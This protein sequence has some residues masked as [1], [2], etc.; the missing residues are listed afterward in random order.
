MRGPSLPQSGTPRP[1]RRVARPADR[2]M[3]GCGGAVGGAWDT[4]PRRGRGDAEHEHGARSPLGDALGRSGRPRRDPLAPLHWP[5]VWSGST[6]DRS[7]TSSRARPPR[8][9]W[10]EGQGWASPSSSSPPAPRGKRMLSPFFFRSA[11]GPRPPP[12]S[13]SLSHHYPTH[14]IAFNGFIVGR[15]GG[16]GVQGCEFCFF[17]CARGE[18][19][20]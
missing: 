14:M 16:V 20:V 7:R 5:R 9:R 8:S 12:P 10:R 19:A 15:V 11:S 13:L 2:V 6:G 3:V 1:A 18:G 17:C 4:G